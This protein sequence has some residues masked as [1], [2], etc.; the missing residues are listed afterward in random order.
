MS[1]RKRVEKD[2]GPSKYQKVEE[3][4]TKQDPSSSKLSPKA[5]ASRP[6]EEKKK[7]QETD[8]C[9]EPPL[10]HWLQNEEKCTNIPP[11]STNELLN[12]FNSDQGT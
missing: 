5:A 11:L 7:Q 6:Q 4:A 12:F 3:S 1:K 9:K 8:A 10:E 2:N